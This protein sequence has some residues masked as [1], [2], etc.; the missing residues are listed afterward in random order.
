MQSELQCMH[1]NHCSYKL[2]PFL[3]ISLSLDISS[4]PSSDYNDKH[5]NG[6]SG[7]GELDKDQP[8]AVDA[9]DLSQD[10]EVPSSQSSSTNWSRTN[11]KDD[12]ISLSKCLQHFTS[13]ETLSEQVHCDVCQQH[14]PSK[15]RLSISAAPKVL[16]LHFKRF[17]SLRQLK[18]CSKVQ[19]PLR[20]LDLAPFVRQQH[21]NGIPSTLSAGNDLP[22]S[23][24]VSRSNSTSDLDGQDNH[25]LYDLQ[26]IVN[27]KGSLTQV[28]SDSIHL[29]LSIDM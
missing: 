23:G 11:L 7:L 13:L 4:T 12:S 2:E 16:I 9:I 24:S 20:G 18:I 28:L 26:G 1:C 17:D 14:R 15:K 5:S 27:H 22:D 25:L 29:V 8:E 19:F 10:S 21:K 6:F 3:D